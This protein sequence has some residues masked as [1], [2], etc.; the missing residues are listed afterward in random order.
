[1]YFRNVFFLLLLVQVEAQLISASQNEGKSTRWYDNFGFE[2]VRKRFESAMQ[3]PL[4]AK[5]G[6]YQSPFVSNGV[7]ATYE[8]VL[9]PSYPLAVR[10]PYLSGISCSKLLRLSFTD[11]AKAWVPGNQVANFATATPQF[12]TGAD[13]TWGVLARVDGTTYKLFG[14]SESLNDSAEATL[15]SAKYTLHALRLHVESWRCCFW[16]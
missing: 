11:T 12:W 5:I 2:G 14:A 8:P 16:T 9:P 6:F 15:M 13:L 4:F 7:P 1:M 3:L 10:S